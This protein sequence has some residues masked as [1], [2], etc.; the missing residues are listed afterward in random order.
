MFHPP[1]LQHSAGS[2]QMLPFTM[3]TY[4]M[5]SLAKRIASFGHAF[6][7]LAFMLGTQHNAW[8]HLLA[9]AAVI[10]AGVWLNLS[11]YDW[12]WIVLAIGIVWVAEIVNTAFEHLCDVVQPEFHVSVKAA[13]DVAAGAV[14]VA[15]F[16]ALIIGLL[17]FLPYLGLPL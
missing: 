9:T 12:R 4:A 7:G 13:K 5:F 16:T 17:V 3:G 15:A 11:F 2:R 8:I 6:R 14:L 10:A 1:R